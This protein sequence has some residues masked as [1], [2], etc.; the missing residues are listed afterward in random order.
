MGR[1]VFLKVTGGVAVFT[2]PPKQWLCHA[3]TLQSWLMVIPIPKPIQAPLASL[4]AMSSKP[5]PSMDAAGYREVVR[6]QNQEQ[7]APG[8]LDVV[9][10]GSQPPRY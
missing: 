6:S 1:P 8:T 10:G 3:L 4:G 7:M 2:G 5:M 9:D